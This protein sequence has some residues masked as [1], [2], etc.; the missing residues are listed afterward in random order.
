M[1]NPRAIHVLVFDGFA[2][3]EPAHALAEMGL[4]RDF[5]ETIEHQ[6][7]PLH[8]GRLLQPLVRKVFKPLSLFENCLA[9][10]FATGHAH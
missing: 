9:V 10:R 2:D 3:W 6:L 8:V 4:V 7:K 1:T 5:A